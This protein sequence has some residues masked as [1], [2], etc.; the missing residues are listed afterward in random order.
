MAEE[1]TYR[2]PAFIPIQVYYDDFISSVCIQFLRNIGELEVTITN[3]STGD[4]ASYDIDS[5]SGTVIIPINGDS[6]T[7][8]ITLLTSNMSGYEGEFEI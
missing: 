3:L 5:N 4:S 2:A 1:T 6:G 7:Y 8:D